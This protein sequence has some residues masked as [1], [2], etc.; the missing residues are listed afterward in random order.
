MKTQ[1]RHELQTNQLADSIGRYLQTVRPYQKQLSFGLIA[2]VVIVGAVIWLNNQQQSQASASWSNFFDALAEQKPDALEDV[3]RLH[4]DST[5]ALWAQLSAGDMKLAGGAAMLYVDRKDAEKNLRDAEKAF[6]AVEQGAARYPLLLQRAQFGLGQVYESLFS[7][8]KARDAYKRVLEID[9]DSALADVAKRRIE[10]LSDQSVESWY[11]WFERQQ[12]VPPSSAPATSGPKVPA[13]LGV[14]PER[15][16]LSFP[17]SEISKAISEAVKPAAGDVKTEPA[18][19]D[20]PNEP[21]PDAA[22]PATSDNPPPPAKP[23]SKPA[24]TPQMPPET[25]TTE[26]QG[27]APPSEKPA[28]AP[29][30]TPEVKETP[31]TAPEAKE[32]A[33]PADAQSAPAAPSAEAPATPKPT[34]PSS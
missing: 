27:D 32:E 16:D 26:A 31:P 18:A 25:P 8:E 2:L 30:T 10:A 1:R 13:D 17:G 9:A 19:K 3:V 20:V 6:L 4:P 21:A 24:G 15:P 12:P 23:E 11:A 34:E 14:L 28:E 29:P 33:K 22:K 5:A 7:V